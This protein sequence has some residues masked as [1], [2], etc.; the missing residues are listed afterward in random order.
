MK[1]KDENYDNHIRELIKV[2]VK[3]IEKEKRDRIAT[4]I[5]RFLDGAMG[6]IIFFYGFVLF[7]VA[8]TTFFGGIYLTSGIFLSVIVIYNLI[9]IDNN[10]NIYRIKLW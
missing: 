6:A 7:Q 5:N 4:K 8:G 9:K 3:K 10:K 2:E 1:N